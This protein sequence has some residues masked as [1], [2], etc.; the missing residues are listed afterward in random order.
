[1]IS[2]VVLFMLGSGI[3]GGAYNPA[4][5][6][7]GRAV[8]GIGGGGINMFIELIVCDLV[9]LRERGNFMGMIFAVFAIGTSVGPVIGGIIADH[10]SWRWVFYIKYVGLCPR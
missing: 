6:L 5:L 8:Q 4:M 9:P 3:A 2:F 10:S 7:A 1:M